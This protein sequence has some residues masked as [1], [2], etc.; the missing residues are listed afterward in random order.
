MT[1]WQFVA[2]LGAAAVWPFAARAQQPLLPRV[3]VI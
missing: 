3:G 2:L 1:R